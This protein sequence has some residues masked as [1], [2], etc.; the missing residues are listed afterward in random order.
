MVYKSQIIMPRPEQIKGNSGK[1]QGHASVL[2]STAA[3]SH[4]RRPGQGQGPVVE[5]SPELEP[6]YDAGP[7]D[8][9]PRQ[10]PIVD[11]G[12]TEEQRFSFTE[13]QRLILTQEQQLM[14]D[15]QIEI[16]DAVHADDPQVD[17]RT[18]D[19]N[20]QAEDELLSDSDEITEPE[21][22]NVPRDIRQI[23]TAAAGEVEAIV[24][25][26][27]H[28]RYAT[29]LSKLCA[30]TATTEAE[31]HVR[32]GLPHLVQH[33]GSLNLG[34]DF[35]ERPDLDTYSHAIVIYMWLVV[36]LCMQQ[37]IF[38]PGTSLVFEM[39]SLFL[40]ALAVLEDDCS[41]TAG[42]LS[43]AVQ[44]W[45]E[46]IKA[47]SK[48]NFWLRQQWFKDIP[49][50][51]AIFSISRNEIA[52]QY[53]RALSEKG[54]FGL[55][56]AIV[57]RDTENIHRSPL[58]NFID[59]GERH[60]KWIG[61]ELADILVSMDIEVLKALI[62]GSLTRKSEIPLSKVSSVL[63]RIERQTPAPPSIYQN[64]IC[65]RMGLSPTPAQWQNVCDHMIAYVAG[66]KE[67]DGLAES[68]DQLVYPSNKWPP[69]LARI[70]LR[71]YTEWR[72]YI[73]QDGD[74]HPS[75]SRRQMVRYFA[76]QMQ[77]RIK[78]DLQTGKGHIPLTAPVI[79]IG[80][81]IDHVGRRREH[82]QHRNSNYLMNL[83]EALIK[84]LY[85]GYFRL[86][87][88]VIYSCYQ[89]GQCWFSEVILTQIGQGYTEG[90][91]GFSHYTAG[92]SNGAPYRKTSR[93]DW[94][95][96]LYEAGR[97]GDLKRERKLFIAQIE[98]EEAAAKQ[99]AIREAENEE[100]TNNFLRAFNA[101]L[102]AELALAQSFL[103]DQ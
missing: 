55:L 8:F 23:E 57:D 36:C 77:D 12:S 78:A 41:T 88:L 14:M 93:E 44:Y 73:D 24:D 71:R 48:G 19:A 4:Q 87:Q 9:G 91:G 64:A 102:D 100:R 15:T 34:Q 11:D 38:P 97:S 28:G 75:T 6:H 65:D 70:G 26:T 63:Q 80:F 50:Q 18:Q 47:K 56:L 96:F 62:D 43:F 29:F 81:S 95:K 94:A 31:S 49:Q 30:S 32:E 1:G 98:I 58:R 45:E 86:Q 40:S 101:V 2:P 42:E 33:A 61:T 37:G 85:P 16:M 72:S 89:P 103:G 74:R 13:E 22:Y 76:R 68:V 7:S 3:A 46:R 5:S 25:H 84:Y 59:K 99:K 35:T 83:A 20:I 10:D 52:D 79:E 82:R 67:S 21:T 51:D 60:S 27:V 69:H 54:K 17:W 92:L 66:G 90:G 39:G 53:L